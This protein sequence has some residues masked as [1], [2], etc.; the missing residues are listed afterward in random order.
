M[1]NELPSEPEK[2]ETP[3]LAILWLVLAFIPS[4][5]ALAALKGTLSAIGPI[6]LIIGVL[7]CLLGGLG[8]AG[9]FKESSS[10]VS[11][12]IGLLLAGVF[13]VLN[14]IIVVLIGCSGMGRIAP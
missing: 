4:V 7:C 8:V 6:L 3:E 12:P 13:F 5:I 9:A 14:V 2:P 10:A 1:N 11:I